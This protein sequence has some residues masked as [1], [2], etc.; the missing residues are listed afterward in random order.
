[1]SDDRTN[2]G[3]LLKKS[4]TVI[5][6]VVSLDFPELTNEALEST[7]HSSGG[8][9]SYISGKLIELTEFSATVNFTSISGIM[10]DLVAGTEGS[11]GIYFPDVDTTT[12]TFGAYVVGFK[13]ETAD[14]TKPD[15]LKATVRFR[16]TGT[17]TIE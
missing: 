6:E 11:Y 2:Y 16:P 1:M 4:T 12:F 3:A 13:P 14:A 15:V 17:V 7:N 10:T 9:K 8:Y 5:G